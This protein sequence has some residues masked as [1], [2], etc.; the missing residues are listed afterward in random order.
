MAHDRS[1]LGDGLGMVMRNKRYIFWFW[2]LNIT[3][4]QFGAAA[5]RINAHKLL[6]T[7]LYSG[8]LVRGFDLGIFIDLLVRP[9]TGQFGAMTLPAM[10]F[11]FVFFLAM[12]IF[13]PGVIAG[14]ASNYR[15]PR[16][17]F[18]RACGRNLWRFIR[19]LII[20]GIIMGIA[21]GLLFTL[22]GV[23]E[24]QAEK[25]TNE[26]LLPYVRGIGLLI[27]FL[28]MSC[29]RIWFDLAEAD[30]VLSDQPAVRRSIAA[31]LRH[32]FRNL[33]RL[34]AGYVFT[35]IVAGLILAAGIWTWVHV[36]APQSLGAAFL[37]T[38]L[39]L[40]L[41]LIPRFWQRGIVVSYWQQKM[42]AP[43]VAPPAP[44]LDTGAFTA[45]A[46]A[47]PVGP[48]DPSPLAG[49]TS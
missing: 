42:I 34:L 33:F 48:T 29:F 21:A 30:I 10:F 32:T 20:S 25:S 40:F 26:M 13:V 5:F 12:T 16:E 8:G 46:P 2:L 44:V 28:I 14:F 27:I 22:H 38:Q 35:A 17:D 24:R 47:P 36:L 15:L 18:F 4:A 23:F 31:A 6:D 45:P 39:T 19:L 37:I 11:A 49:A 7:S 1:L 41:L 9:D 43:V 3:L